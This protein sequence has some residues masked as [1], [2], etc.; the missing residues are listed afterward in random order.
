M[1]LGDAAE[2][3]H[4]AAADKAAANAA[5]RATVTAVSTPLVSI[6]R[7]AETTGST[8]T[9]AVATPF[10]LAI[11]DVVLCLPLGDQP[12]ILG[13][14]QRTAPVDAELAAPAI[15]DFTNAP[16]HARERGRRGRAHGLP[17]EGHRATSRRPVPA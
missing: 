17:E 5:F 16:A 13:I 14:I 4:K 7:E 12:V 3:I 6:R 2:A 1:S 8:A 9:Y 11:G 15:D 10:V